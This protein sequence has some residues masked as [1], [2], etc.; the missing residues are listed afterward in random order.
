MNIR[1]TLPLLLVSFGLFFSSC[2]GPG[3][4]PELDPI[5]IS[6]VVNCYTGS[7]MEGVTIQISSD[8]SDE[9]Q[10]ETDA[11]GFYSVSDLPP[12][13]DYVV[14]VFYEDNTALDDND[15]EMLKDYIQGGATNLDDFQILSVDFN[16]TGVIG[17]TAYSTLE[18]LV[19][20]YVLTEWRFATADFEL[21]SPDNP[22][23]TGQVDEF[24]VAAGDDD[25]VFD[26]VGVKI[27]DLD[28]SSCD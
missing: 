12:Q 5:T 19:D 25:V 6:G 7:P 23:G 27:G 4:S 8:M 2:L 21:P 18:S 26:L 9:V 13:L 22:A 10:I 14:K 11:S 15:K 28:G 16:G 3:D 1:F 20:D 17:F 24:Y